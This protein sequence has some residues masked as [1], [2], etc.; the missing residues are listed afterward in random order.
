MNKI[1]FLIVIIFI[2]VLPLFLFNDAIAGGQDK[3][4]SAMLGRDV[5]G[6]IYVSGSIV[7]NSEKD[8][9]KAN[10]TLK[11][12]RHRGEPV[13]GA[14]IV[15]NNVPL[16][17]GSSGNYA[18]TSRSRDIRKK[19]ATGGMLGISTRNRNNINLKIYVR[20]G[21]PIE[22]KANMNDVMRLSIKPVYRR[23]VNLSAPVNVSW[24]STRRDRNRTSFAI[25]NSRGKIVF[26]KPDRPGKGMQLTIRRRLV[27]PNGVYTFRVSKFKERI[28]NIPNASAGSY[29]DLFTEATDTHRVFK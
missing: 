19:T 20:G 22:I 11:N 28:D 6:N 7:I 8:K 1:F 17:E 5:S 18:G 10:I 21:A 23:G 4:I 25:I 27:P 15:F 3:D 14:R 29:I 12:I 24:S 13:R 2:M 9:I 16:R 26:E